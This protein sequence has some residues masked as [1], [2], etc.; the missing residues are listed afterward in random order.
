[1]IHI[2]KFKNFNEEVEINNIIKYIDQSINESFDI[3]K[4]WNNVINKIRNFSTSGKK[5]IIK[6]AILSMLATNTIS[7]ITNIINNS[8]AK[9]EDK[10]IAIEVCDEIK[11]EYPHL[12]KFFDSLKRKSALLPKDE[13]HS[14]WKESAQ[15]IADFEEFENFASFLTEIGIIQLREKD[16]RY[17]FADIYVYG[18]KMDRQG[19]V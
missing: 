2:S 17:K 18:F 16:Q 11:E 4:I 8:N 15:D 5:K 12:T 3:G 14:I 13:L 9:V 1:M 19:A 6:Y 7:G 10:K